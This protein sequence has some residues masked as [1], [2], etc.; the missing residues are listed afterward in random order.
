MTAGKG[1]MGLAAAARNLFY[2]GKRRQNLDQKECHSTKLMKK[3]MVEE[4]S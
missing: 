2:S 1:P 3:E 4:K